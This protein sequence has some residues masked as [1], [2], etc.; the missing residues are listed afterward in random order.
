MHPSASQKEVP[1]TLLAKGTVL[2]FFFVGGV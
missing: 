1:I 2:A